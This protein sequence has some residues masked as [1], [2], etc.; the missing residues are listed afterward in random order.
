MR[1]YYADGR[2]VFI[3]ENF[4]AGGIAHP[5]NW[6]FLYSEEDLNRYGITYV[7]EEDPIPAVVS[8]PVRTVSTYTMVKRLEEAG[9]LE[10]ANAALEANLSAKARFY[11]IGSIKIDDPETLAMLTYIQA[12]PEVIMAPE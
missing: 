11:T 1:R 4:E 8:E 6:S 10:E 5:G 12:D 2:E 9:K 7:D 3:T